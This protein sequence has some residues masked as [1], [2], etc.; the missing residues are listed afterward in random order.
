M[1]ISRSQLKKAI[2]R[3]WK[4]VLEKDECGEGHGNIQEHSLSLG[5]MSSLNFR[6]CIEEWYYAKMKLEKQAGAGS[7]RSLDA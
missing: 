1:M 5:T 3:R 6:L 2:A 7:Q 4:S